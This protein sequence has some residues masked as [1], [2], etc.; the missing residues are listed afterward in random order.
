MPQALGGADP[1]ARLFDPSRDPGEQITCE[2]WHPGPPVFAELDA[3]DTVA[4]RRAWFW[5]LA[6][7]GDVLLP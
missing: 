6:F 7:G 3:C 2:D 1:V 4:K 5:R